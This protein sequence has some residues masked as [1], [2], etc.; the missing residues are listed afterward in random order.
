MEVTA[1]ADA[2]DRG[3]DMTRMRLQQR[4]IAHRRRSLATPE[5]GQVDRDHVEFVPQQQRQRSE[6][7]HVGR[8]AVQEHDALAHR[9]SR[10]RAR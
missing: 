9:G 8:V 4:F 6:V 7:M 2:F 3:L 1:P 5:T 10:R